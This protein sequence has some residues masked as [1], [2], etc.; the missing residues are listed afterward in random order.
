MPAVEY[1]PP[2]GLSPEH[3]WEL[4][5]A[6]VDGYALSA[7]FTAGPAASRENWRQG[8]MRLLNKAE[9]LGIIAGTVDS[10]EVDITTDNG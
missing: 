10:G 8:I 9:E 3:A 1:T 4:Y 6:L 5:K 7:M 2:E